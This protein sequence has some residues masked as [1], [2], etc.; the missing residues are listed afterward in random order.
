[1]SDPYVL[2]ILVTSGDPEGVRVVEKSNWSGQGVVF[3]RADLGV[4]NGHGISSPG[5]YVLV[6]EDPDGTFDQ[7][8]YVGQGEEVGKR[9]TQH[10]RDESK[11]FWNGTVVFVSKDGGLN[12]AHILHLEA[13][14]LELADASNRVAV[15]N[16]NRPSPPSLSPSANAEAEGFLR[17]MLG[18]FPVLGIAA[19]EKP[20][21]ADPKVRRRYFLKGPDAEGEGED[22]P[23]GFLV[24]AG[25]KA[26]VDEVASLTPSFVRLRARLIASG[27]LVERNGTYEL[28]DDY[29]F[30]SPSLAAVA[31]LG[32]NANGRTEWRDTA[33]VT[34]KEHQEAAADTA[35]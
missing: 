1:M 29:L 3:G 11:D 22:R 9:L 34:L 23:D 27:H 14:L 16:G 30:S 18:I 19:F 21:R 31:L 4:A 8:I 17:E 13:R 5:I 32:R 28:T 6:G 2:T 12:R 20:Q 24:L 25:A 15:A 33:G 26:R 35:T 7:R 10:Q